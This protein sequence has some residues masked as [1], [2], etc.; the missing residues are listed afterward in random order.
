[1]KTIAKKID[2]ICRVS[3]QGLTPKS[4]VDDLMQVLFNA[5]VGEGL[6]RLA[7]PSGDLR[8]DSSFYRELDQY[9]ADPEAWERLGDIAEDY[10]LLMKSRDPFT[11]L[12]GSLY[13]QIRLNIKWGQFLTPWPVATGLTG[14]HNIDLRDGKHI[15]FGDTG[16]CGAGTLLLAQLQDLYER[17][18]A[19]LRQVH[20]VA[21]DIDWHMVI[22]STVQIVY[23]LLA[24]NIELG[25]FRNYCGHGIIDYDRPTPAM[26][27]I[28]D[29]KNWKAFHEQRDMKDETFFL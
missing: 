11:D 28:P 8:V 23:P 10:L 17:Q 29:L 12:V 25:S 20:V 3:K 14:F 13:S 21:L 27:F 26:T 22:M 2:E 18:P 5:L 4:V 9:R 1:M 6:F 15:L 7:F 16:G 24:C 19:R